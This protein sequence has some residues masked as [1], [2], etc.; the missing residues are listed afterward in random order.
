MLVRTTVLVL[1]LAALGRTGFGQQPRRPT[2]LRQPSGVGYLRGVVYD[3][4]LEAPLPG[5]RVTVRGTSLAATTDEAGRFR[6]D[7]VPT[8]TVVLS[9]KHPG[10]DSAGLSTLAQPAIIEAGRPTFAELT[11]PSHRTLRRLA[12]RQDATFGRDSGLVLGSLSDAETG[13]RVAGAVVVASWVTARRGGDGR[14]EVRRPRVVMTT[15]SVGNFYGCDVTTDLVMTLQAATPDSFRS[16]AVE[17]LIGPR[18]VGR[19]DLSVSREDVPGA[20]DTT[21][22]WRGLATLVGVVHEEHG[23]SRPSAAVTVDD[24]PG[25]AYA[26]SAGQFVL[27][28]LPS[29]S[30]MILARMIGYSAARRRVELRNH[31]TT[32]VDLVMRAVTVLDT[33]RITASSRVSQYELEDLEHRMRTGGAYFLAGEEVKDRASMRSVFQGLPSLTIEGRSQFEY[34]LYTLTSG[35]AC[36]V[37]LWVDGTRSDVQ[38]IQTYRPE[39]IIAVEWY[40]RGNSAPARFLT[41]NDNQNCGVLLVWTRFIR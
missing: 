30:H 4:L 5:A 18:G 8:G 41:V 20:R 19:Y 11:V 14:V 2:P 33:L 28:D 38:S 13:E 32:R 3:S 12:C 17:V 6:I 31:D 9:Y 16:G 15:D 10:L 25:V 7:S 24:V 36:P 23:L 1:A 29:G 21:G 37:A 34:A 26:D 39:Q 22:H 27:T 40:P 35:R